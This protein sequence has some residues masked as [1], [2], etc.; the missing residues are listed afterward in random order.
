MSDSST[1]PYSAKSLGWYF[2]FYSEPLW[3][4]LAGTIKAVI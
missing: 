1:L 2:N 4:H 3:T